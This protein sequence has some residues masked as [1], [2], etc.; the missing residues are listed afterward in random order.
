MVAIA[1][2]VGACATRTVY[3]T[4]YTLESTGQIKTNDV[5][6]VS[7]DYDRFQIGMRT[8]IV[9]AQYNPTN[10]APAEVTRLAEIVLHSI[11]KAKAR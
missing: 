6:K 5:P 4:L 8:A 7:Q 9:A 1:L 11:L 10:L 2:F 3:N